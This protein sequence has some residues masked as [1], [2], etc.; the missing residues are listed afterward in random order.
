MNTVSTSEE[1][2]DKRSSIL[3]ML[4]KLLSQLS[5]VLGFNLTSYALRFSVTVVIARELGPAFYGSLA[6]IMSLSA[7]LFLPLAMGQHSVMYKY[8]STAESDQRN[9]RMW[10][11]LAG[12]ML[13]VLLIGSALF[14]CSEWIERWFGI[15]QSFWSIGILLAVGNNFQAISESF[16]RGQSRFLTIGVA[17]LASTIFMVIT[18]MVVLLQSQPNVFWVAVVFSLG[19]FTFS[20]MALLRAGLRR[21]EFNRSFYGLSVKYGGSMMLGQILVAVLFEGDILLLKGFLTESDL[22]LYAAHLGLL[23]QIFFIFFVEIFCVVFLPALAKAN[24]S[25]I[26]ETGKAYLPI[27]ILTLYSLSFIAL[28][29]LLRLFGHGFSGSWL[30]T[31]LGSAAI[32]LFT[33]FQLAN[34]LLTMDG[35]RAARIGSIAV[36]CC[37]PFF[38]VGLP[39]GAAQYGLTGALASITLVYGAMLMVTLFALKSYYSDR[40]IREAS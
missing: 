40:L 10:T 6:F 26:W 15:D 4:R 36:A 38:I 28:T 13:F 16:L 11:V 39:W 1:L 27:A 33:F 32:T 31:V 21:P 35:G 17:R 23:K 24:R 2:S 37:L 34:H 19:T 29:L 7:L 14:A 22:G 25:S 18:M 9:E 30:Y 5:I 3:L 20:L 8:L 12:N